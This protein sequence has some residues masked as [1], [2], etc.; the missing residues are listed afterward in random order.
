MRVV[1]VNRF[2]W[3][4]EPATAQLLTD[5]AQALAARGHSITVITSRASGSPSRE[6][7]VGVEIR[8]VV[9]TRWGRRSLFGRAIDFMAFLLAASWCLVRTVGRQD[10]VVAM[11]DPPLLGLVVSAA[12]WLKSARCLHWVQDVYP[13]VAVALSG[14]PGLRIFGGGVRLLRNLSWK[15]SAGCVALGHDMAALIAQAG[16]PPE[17]IAIIPN[18]SPAGLD[19]PS[20]SA[21]AECRRRW[22][23]EDRF[24]AAYSG[25]LGRVHDLGP[26]LSVAELLRDDARIAFLFVGGGAQRAPLEQFA[27]ERGLSNVRFEPA[28]PRQQLAAAL[29][30]GDVHFVTLHAA[31]AALVFP[32]KFYGIAA[33][34]RPVFFIGPPESEPARLVEEHD[35]GRAFSRGETSAIAAALT[36]LATDH[37]RWQQLA[38]NA[39]T[40]SRRHG[41]LEHALVAWEHV[42]RDAAC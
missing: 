31:C 18:W 20:S 26:V 1:F 12:V 7:H 33:V 8:R 35:M 3:P 30:A 37:A 38:A 13:E 25:N 27:R 36:Q 11:T 17:R 39:A 19:V 24:V 9:R 5:L 23:L 14:A 40:F 10:V 32:S 42:L 21:V 22:G 29:A 41:R 28:Q 4:E 16:V 34:G 6:V 15:S 2:Y